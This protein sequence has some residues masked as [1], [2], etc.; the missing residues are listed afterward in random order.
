[1]HAKQWGKTPYFYSCFPLQDFKEDV[2]H[3]I[4]LMKMLH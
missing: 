4:S 3:T 1:M 2:K